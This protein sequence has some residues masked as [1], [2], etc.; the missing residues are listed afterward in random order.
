MGSTL[1]SAWIKVSIVYDVI[2]WYDE[3]RP[4]IINYV[5]KSRNL[6]KKKMRKFAS[7]QTDNQVINSKTEAT[8]ILSG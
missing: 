2:T 6:L 1:A 7:R 8:L 4:V 3:R 5:K